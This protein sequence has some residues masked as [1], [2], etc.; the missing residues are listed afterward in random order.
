MIKIR[1]SIIIPAY[2]ATLYIKKCLNSILN[3]AYNN[4]E[5]IIV[6][7]GSTDDTLQILNDYA[8]RYSH[9]VILSQNNAGPGA[10]REYALKHVTGDYVMF[11]DADDYWENNFLTG[12]NT[13]IDKL[14]PDI[15]EFGY[16]KVDP[17]GVIISSHSIIPM[18]LT[19]GDC[20]KHYV[21]QKNTTNYLCNKVFCVKLF[22]DVNFPHLYA[23]EDAALLLQLF[24]HAKLY[25]SVPETYYNY[26]MSPTSLC[27]VPFNAR[28]LDILKSDSFMYDYLSKIRTDLSGRL[29]YAICARSAVL[30]CELMLS[31]NEDKNQLR[32]MI[33]RQ[34]KKY[35]SYIHKNKEA[36]ESY[37]LQRKGIVFLFGIN[38]FLCVMLY[39]LIK[40]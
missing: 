5:V 16:R 13:N 18:Q 37:S 34:Y 4:F 32:I 17:N 10:A 1:Y 11:S 35:R 24:S 20:A 38:P 9:V 12:I 14:H 25:I 28:K 21:L 23:G 26:V 39:K 33:K 3:Q 6:N 7:D 40:E 19:N 30:Y 31:N 22:K 27:R 8:E 15:L 29:A 2:N 36:S